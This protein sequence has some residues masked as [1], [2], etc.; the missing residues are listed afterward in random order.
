MHARSA[1]VP[2]LALAGLVTG[3]SAQTIGT[4]TVTTSA[5]TVNV[6]ETFTIGV[7]LSDNIP[8]GSVFA[9]DVEV[10][11]AGSMSIA[12]ITDPVPEASIFGFAGSATA[13]GATGLGGSS[14]ILGPS[15]DAPLDGVTVYSFQSTATSTGSR[16]FTPGDGSWDVVFGIA[17]TG[18]SSGLIPGIALIPNPYDEIIFESITITVIPAP[19]AIALLALALPLSARRKR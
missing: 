18:S 11:S 1:A 6:G 15:F 19:P 4:V 13:T 17:W 5:T 10:S 14:D 12:G 9:F 2:V 16:T 3:V 7:L 8:G